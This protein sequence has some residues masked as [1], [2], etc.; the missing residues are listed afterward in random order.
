[1]PL[2]AKRE[3]VRQA[4]SELEAAATLM[5]PYLA[6]LDAFLHFIFE[7]GEAM[8][9]QN[10]PRQNTME[11]SDLFVLHEGAESTFRRYLHLYPQ[12]EGEWI[13]VEPKVFFNSSVTRFRQIL[14]EEIAWLRKYAA[15]LRA[16]ENFPALRQNKPATIYNIQ[17]D[18]MRDQYKDF[19]A[20]AVGPRAKASNTT[21]QVWQN[22]AAQ[23]DL[24]EL[25]AALSD[26]RPK[27]KAADLD[28]EYDEEI[29]K[30]ASAEKAAKSGDGE[31][32]L[33]HLK[34]AGKW[35]LDVAVKVGS[36]VAVKAITGA[37]DLP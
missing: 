12:A 13:R 3:E 37:I 30:V 20:A 5:D 26:L 24:P 35:V 34:D 21:I 18:Y 22:A 16:K 31:K 1:M 2:K 27:L 25:S 6:R 11:I 32:T 33:Q 29:G 10:I 7:Q 4:V 15:Y 14:W 17:G 36:T 8:D 19:T 28:G 23:L 9:W